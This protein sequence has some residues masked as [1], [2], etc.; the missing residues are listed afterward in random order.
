MYKTEL[1][2]LSI[3]EALIDFIGDDISDSLN[4]TQS[5]SKH[6]GGSATNLALNCAKLGV[7]TQ[8]IASVGDDEFGQHIIDTINLTGV[9]TSAIKQVKN[10]KSIHKSI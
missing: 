1:Q 10:I 6:I 7:S 4:K 8:L 3:G 2:I 5:F 9:N